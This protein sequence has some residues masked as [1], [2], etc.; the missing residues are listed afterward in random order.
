[1][2]S[3]TAFILISST[4]VVPDNYKT[5]QEAVTTA[6]P[7]DTILV[8]EGTYQENVVVTK[9]LSIRSR[10]GAEHTTVRAAVPAEPVFKLSNADGAE[11]SGFTATGSLLAGIY[12]HNSTNTIIS[13]NRA[14]KN[15]TGIFLHAS[16]DN[17]LTGN[18][19]DSNSKYGIYLETSHRNSLLKNNANINNDNGIFLSYSND[20]NLTDNNANLNVWNGV[21]LWDSRNNTLKENRTWRNR[22]GIVIGEGGNNSLI[23]NSTWSNI[24]VIMPLV[25]VYLGIISYLIQKRILRTIYRV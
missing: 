19:A 23:D 8:S 14:V 17:R 2:L 9:P 18:S 24:Y 12:L 3:L 21:L 5:I 25:L 10:K 20:N 15:G 16:S 4:I 6:S 22:F 11:V 1:M 13:D 7:G